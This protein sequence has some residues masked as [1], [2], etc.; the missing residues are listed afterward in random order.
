MS[1]LWPPAVDQ[2]ARCFRLENSSAPEAYQV[3]NLT[4]WFE[5]SQNV[6]AVLVKNEVA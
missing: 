1:N 5:T 2:K 3:R 6:R 4:H